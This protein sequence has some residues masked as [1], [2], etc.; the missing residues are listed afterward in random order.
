[1]KF[2]IGG[3]EVVRPAQAAR[4]LGVRTRVITEAMYRKT[5]AR[6]SLPDGTLG[7]P[8]DDLSRFAAARG[9]DLTAA[10]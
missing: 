7:I 8:V 6:V 5:I 1:V 2:V 10:G 3:V 4:M 9:I